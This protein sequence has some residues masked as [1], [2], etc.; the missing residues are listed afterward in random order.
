LVQRNVENLRWA[1]LLNVDDAFRRFSKW[2][3]DRLADTIGATRGAIAAALE[4]RRQH[5]EK[6]EAALSEL[7]RA[8][9]YVATVKHELSTESGLPS[10][11]TGKAD[12]L[13]TERERG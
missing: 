8:A 9:E 7:R 6:A 2:F 11:A 3:D 5:A 12:M 13:R 10:T 1:T 4:Q